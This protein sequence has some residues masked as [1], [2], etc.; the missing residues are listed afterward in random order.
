[1][2]TEIRRVLYL[3]VRHPVVVEVGGGSE[4]LPT[5]VA[6]MRFLSRVD[7]SVGVKR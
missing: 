6:F 1:M 3:A 2:W 7:P 4:P 5:D